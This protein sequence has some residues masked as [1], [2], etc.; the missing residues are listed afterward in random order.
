MNKRHYKLLIITILALFILDKAFNI[1]EPIVK[2]EVVITPEITGGEKKMLNDSIKTDTIYITKYIQGNPKTLV[3]VVVDSTYKKEYEKAIKENDTLKAKNLFLESISLDT[4]KGTLI[5]NKDVKI[6]GTFVTRGKLLEYDVKYKIK[7]DTISYTPKVISQHPKLSLIYG[8]ELG[9][10]IS[11][12]ENPDPIAI[13][14][15]GL[16]FKKG[17]I[18]SAGLSS[19]GHIM[20]GY[21]RSIKL[22]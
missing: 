12:T 20:I 19:Q 2:D 11:Q 15:I 3:E 22:F 4:F 18:I 9:V 7:S 1:Q 6:D 17:S 10:N 5:D 16:Q 8:G 21:S 14:R 13:G